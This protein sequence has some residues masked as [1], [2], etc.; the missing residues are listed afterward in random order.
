MPA[1]QAELLQ[2]RAPEASAVRPHT[3]GR[4]VADPGKP[5]A[6]AGVI[7]SLPTLRCCLRNSAV[8]TAHTR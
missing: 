2:L 4:Q 6:D 3:T 5:N 8:T 1:P 7:K